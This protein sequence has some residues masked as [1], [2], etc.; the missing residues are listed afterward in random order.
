MRSCGRRQKS[1]GGCG[2][3]PGFLNLRPPFFLPLFAPG[4][5]RR[6]SGQTGCATF[7][8][9]RGC[10]RRGF[11]VL[12]PR[13]GSSG[14]RNAPLCSPSRSSAPQ[15]I[16]CTA[17]S[18]RRRACRRFLRRSHEEKHHQGMLPSAVRCVVLSCAA[19]ARSE[20][21]KG[22]VWLAS[23]LAHRMLNRVFVKSLVGHFLLV[24]LALLIRSVLALP[25]TR[26]ELIAHAD[27]APPL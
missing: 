12:M 10:C 2:E 21:W 27:G 25:T 23:S 19:R 17:M 15:Q 8:R 18:C 7:L 1:S 3:R 20:Q 4:R 14:S 5:W 13:Q 22:E 6:A 11:L 26:A 9:R 16:Y 24:L